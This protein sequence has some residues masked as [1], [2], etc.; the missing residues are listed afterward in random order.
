MDLTRL[1]KWAQDHI[2]TLQRERDNAVRALNEYCDSQ[3]P[4]KIYVDHNESLVEQAGAS[5]KRQFVQSEKV[6]IEHGN[7]LLNVATVYGQD[8]SLQWSAP[9]YRTL[10][11]AFIPESYCRAR[12]VAK[13]YMR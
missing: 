11:I 7:V 2:K 9:N 4:S 13:E 5:T 8:I 6:T 3:T 12:L 1:P 10:D